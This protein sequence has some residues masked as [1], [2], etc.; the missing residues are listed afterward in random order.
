MG[1]QAESLKR[2]CHIY[3]TKARN[4]SLLLNVPAA[5]ITTM[6]CQTLH[7]CSPCCYPKQSTAE[8]SSVL[9][10]WTVNSILHSVVDLQDEWRLFFLFSSFF[11]LELLSEISEMW[12]DSFSDKAQQII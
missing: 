3:Q 7:L 8:Q 2:E 6:P 5:R 9:A 11:K 10:W 1:V 12:A 4:P